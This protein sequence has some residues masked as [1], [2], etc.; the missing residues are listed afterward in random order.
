[1]MAFG[2]GGLWGKGLG[3]STLKLLYLP[4]PHTDFIFPIIGEELGF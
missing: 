4:D 2:S 1:M 3:A